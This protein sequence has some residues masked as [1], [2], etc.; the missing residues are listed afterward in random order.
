FYAWRKRFRK[1]GPV[2]FALV[3]RGSARARV[4]SGAGAGDRRAATARMENSRLTITAPSASS[5]V[6][7][8]G[9]N[10]WMFFGSD[11]GGTTSAV[12]RS[13]VAYCQ[14]V[15][16]DPFTWFNDVLSPIAAHPI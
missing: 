11:Q 5:E 3:E 10:N 2:R 14:R 13:F 1:Q 9:R 4:G 12:L 15:G 16:V 7:A 6:V 8:V